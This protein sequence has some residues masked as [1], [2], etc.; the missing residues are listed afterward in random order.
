MADE[1]RYDESWEFQN[2][3]SDRVLFKSDDFES[4]YTDPETLEEYPAWK[5]DFEARFPDD[6]YEDIEQLK[7]FVSWVVSTYREQATG[8]ALEEAVTYGGVTYD[9]DTEAYRLAKFSAL[10]GDYAEEDS[11]I[12]YYIVTEF[13][14][15]VDS[16]AKNF[17]LG[18]HGGASEVEKMR[19]KAVSEPYDMDTAIGTNNEGTLSYGF[20]LEDTDKVNGADVFNGQSSVLWCN[21][22]DTR[23]AAIVQ[24]YQTLRSSGGFTYEAIERMYEE[25]QAMWP[26]GI[27]NEDAE[28]KYAE[29]LINPQDGKEPTDFYLPMCQGTKE[30]QRKMWLQGRFAYMDSKWNAGDALVQVIQLRGYAK[31]DITV[32]PYIPL[33]PTVKYGSYLVQARSMDATAKTLVC[34]LDEVNDTEIY[35]YSARWVKDVGDLSGLKVGVADF[36]Y[37]VNIQN[38]K[39][40]DSDAQ[41]SNPNLKRLSFGSNVLL[42]KIDARNCPNLG[43]DEQKTVDIS[44]CQIIEEVYFDGTAIQ[45]LTL[46]NGGVLK[47]L[48]VPATMT[49]L[50]VMNQKHITEFV[51]PSYANISTL[52]IENSSI[53]TKMI[54]N[55]VSASTRVRLVGFY[56]ECQDAQEIEDLLDTLDTMRGLSETGANMDTAQVSGTI[57]TA[58][59]TGEQVASYR[60][61]YPYI[62]VDADSVLSYRTYA[63]YD[64]TVLKVVECHDGVPQESAPANPSRTQTAQYTYTFA[65][66]SKSMN[67]ETADSDALDEVTYDRTIYAAYSKTVR[68]YTVTW[69]NSDGTTLETDTGVP[70]GTTPTYN[71][72]TPQNP[73]SGGGAFQG[74]TPSISAV[75]G[76]ITYTASYIPVYTVTF[77]NDDRS[78]I[79]QQT[80]VTQGGSVSYTGSTP[81]STVDSSYTFTGWSGTATNVQS[82]LNIYAQFRAP[83][84]A[85]TSKDVS[86]AY[87]VKWDYANSSP[88]LTRTGLAAAFSDPVPATALAGSGASPFDSIAPWSGM[89]PVNIL[90]DGTIVQKSS[91]SYSETDEDTMVYI[92]EFYYTCWKDTANSEWNWAISPTAKEGYKKHPGSGRYVGR[93]HTG[94]SSSGVY[95]KSGVAP[96]ASV[97]QTDFRTYSHNKGNNWYMLDLAA[98]SAIQLL[99]LVEY[100]TFYSQDALGKGW[101][102]GAVGN[103]GGTAGAAYHTIKATGA[104]NMYRWIEDPF[105]NVRD[106]IDGF[107]ASGRAVY[108]GASDTGYAGGTSDLTRTGITLPTSN[109]FATGLGYSEDAAWAFIPDAASGGSASTH[110]TDYVYSSTGD[111]VASVGGLYSDSDSSGLFCLSAYS[112]A[113][114]AYAHIGSRLLYNP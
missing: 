24:M 62:T 31:D 16:R 60:E 54:L 12:F 102:T 48:H 30:Q 61:R 34:P 27:W 28:V 65:G 99:Y 112:Y 79:L 50:T 52:R 58:S 10:F 37:A 82:N 69:K 85:P 111:R 101:N 55:A 29:P 44:N 100:A 81:V 36:S 14:L 6:T 40:G 45:G 96:L 66:W 26:E 67:A 3:T 38:V 41:Y 105:S 68:T 75:T 15:L 39:L 33:Y 63:D 49:N 4:M 104:H 94:G 95:S 9:H 108:A 7:T 5:N 71:G 90:S 22:R 57:H 32:T 72:S 113:S 51:I 13:F 74:W 17:F 98:W 86:Q 110:L 20:N 21:L 59:L 11:F 78:T 8:D 87:G 88:V 80:T 91:A 23:R 77:Y 1:V 84:D 89:V 97:S 76:N 19:R 109:S 103:V 56:W 70:Y 93:F 106:W 114:S 73:T 83:S 53:D 42:K 35:I 25:A 107:Y 47:K 43:T 92:P 46:P 18:F 64:G 2:N